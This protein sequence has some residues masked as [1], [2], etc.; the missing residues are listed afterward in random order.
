MNISSKLFAGIVGLFAFCTFTYAQNSP[1]LTAKFK[2]A[3][4]A[5]LRILNDNIWDYSQDTIPKMAGDRRRSS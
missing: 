2:L 3:E 1:S 5:D 4:G